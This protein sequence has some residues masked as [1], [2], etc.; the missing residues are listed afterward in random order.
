MGVVKTPQQI[1][2]ED[3]LKR[4]FDDLSALCPTFFIVTANAATQHCNYAVKGAAWVD[5]VSHFMSQNHDLRHAMTVAALNGNLK[6]APLPK[7]GVN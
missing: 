6:P 1:E 4:V 7:A 5:I 3:R 2:Y